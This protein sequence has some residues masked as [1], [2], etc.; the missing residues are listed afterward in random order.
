MN[1]DRK[2]GILLHPT[3]FSG[4]YGI[5]TFG[6]EAFHFIDFLESSKIKLWQILPLGPTGYGDSPYQ[7]FSA[8]ALNPLLIDLETLQKEGLLELED[9]AVLEDIP[10]DRVDYGRLFLYKY[11]V[12]RK[13]FERFNKTKSK[14]DFTE[15]CDNNKSWLED[16]ALFMALK[17]HFNGK[18]WYEW[19]QPLKRRQTKQIKEF[20]D[21]L[22]K[23]IDFQKFMQFEAYSQWGSVK[24]YAHSKMIEI[25]GDIPI[26]IS[27]DSA[28]A[29]GNPGL[30]YFD[31]ELK[32]TIVAGV[33]PD[34]FSA[35]G[36]LWGNPLYRWDVLKKQNYKWWIE[37]IQ[38][39]IKQVD[40]VRL[41]H[42]R[43]FAGYWAVPY[44]EETAVKG[45]WEKGPG[46]DLFD[47]LYQSLGKLPIIAEDLGL[48]TNDVITLR[49]SLGLPGMKILQFAFDSGEANNYLPHYYT[50]NCLVYTG[51][52]DND[53]TYGW[54]KKA[55]ENDR[56]F[57][58]SYLK[59]T[60]ENIVW[61]FIKAA[62]SSVAVFA[63]TPLQDFLELDSEAR[64]NIPGQA[65][66]N[67]Q[68]RYKKGD[69]KR[70]LAEKIANL[71]LLYKR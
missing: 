20:R 71:N 44:G 9:M 35:A 30:F 10:D 16:Y 3:S 60:E 27:Y 6:K 19:E 18:P 61:D 46:K 54:F 41:D 52:H 37:R 22:K 5:G 51:T 26:F 49:E 7:C 2:G 65:S 25:I 33:P 17:N 8:F 58:L 28:D 40:Y 67:W 69:L 11:V 53:T 23:E 66:G 62:W 64:M 57:A 34:Y 70:K 55:N 59:S 24:N 36:Q 31:D 15:F 45:K 42:F 39:T 56:R 68:W 50:P 14:P 38:G 63:I 12:L 4:K 21:R 13:A 47:H 29:W 48:I 1:L 32:P 43:G